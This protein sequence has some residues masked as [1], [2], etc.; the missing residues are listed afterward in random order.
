MSVVSTSTAYAVETGPYYV[1]PDE[2]DALINAIYPLIARS[3]ITVTI[4]SY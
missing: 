2:S 4:A 1:D 3:L